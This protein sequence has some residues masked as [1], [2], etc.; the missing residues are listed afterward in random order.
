MSLWETLSYIKNFEVTFGS[1]CTQMSSV[2][3][4]RKNTLHTLFMRAYM[5][6]REAPQQRMSNSHAMWPANCIHSEECILHA[7]LSFIDSSIWKVIHYDVLWI[8][9]ILREN[10]SMIWLNI[11]IND[12]VLEEYPFRTNT[13][14]VYMLT[15]WLGE[16]GTARLW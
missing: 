6:Q 2:I 15:Y 11:F 4:C 1:H 5:I 14:H 12:R 13:D 9:W 7:R 8:I 10:F 16:E 3:K